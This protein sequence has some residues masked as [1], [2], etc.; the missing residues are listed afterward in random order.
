MNERKETHL[1]LENSFL[2]VGACLGETKADT[3]KDFSIALK[4]NNESTLVDYKKKGKYTPQ[5]V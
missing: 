1:R 3:S 5:S 4:K 2:M